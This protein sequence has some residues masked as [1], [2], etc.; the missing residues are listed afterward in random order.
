[1]ANVQVSGLRSGI[2]MLPCRARARA[3][4]LIRINTGANSRERKKRRLVVDSSWIR[5]VPGPDRSSA[6]IFDWPSRSC[7][8][9][10]V[11][12]MQAGG[13]EGLIKN[14]RMKRGECSKD[15][16]KNKRKESQVLRDHLH[17][18]MARWSDAIKVKYRTSLL[19]GSKVGGY[20]PLSEEVRHSRR[21]YA[22][23]MRTK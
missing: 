14:R 8:R 11:D 16:S 1:M 18:D 2:D 10:A 5:H 7:C 6:L 4:L 15:E 21:A 12:G 9:C 19:V 3:R 17:D 22:R 23:R 13:K 20:A